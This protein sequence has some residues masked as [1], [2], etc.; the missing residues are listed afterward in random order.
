MN[1]QPYQIKIIDNISPLGL[2][3]FPEH[4]YQV[5]SDMK[6]PLAILVRSSSLHD[7]ALASK[8]IVVGRAGAGVNNIPVN[9]YTQLGIPVLNAPGANANAVKELVIAGLLLSS[10]H[11]CQSWQ[12]A[13]QLV[14]N[15]QEI[16]H[17]LEKAKKQ[18]VGNE[19]QGQT[20]GIIGLGSIGVRVANAAIALGMKVIGFDPHITSTNAWQIAS[21]VINATKI[22]QLLKQA[23]YVSLHIP[24]NAQTKH[25]LDEYKLSLLKPNAVLMNFA[26]A[27][28]IDHQALFHALQQQQ[29]ACY[30]SD[31]PC[32]ILQNLPNVINL[33]HL[34][35]STREAQE[36]CAVM[37]ADQVRDY[38]EFGH[39]RHSV[40]FP[41][42]DMPLL[43]GYRIA[44][45]NENIPNMVA[46]ISTCLSDAGL[47]IIDL[48]NKSQDDIAYTLIDVDKPVTSALLA[49]LGEIVGVVRVR[50]IA[51]EAR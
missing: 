45:V 44:I 18:F 43:D 12:F 33:P 48:L 30:V 37:V 26:R 8:T 22:E 15:D 32:Q 21:Q 34:G 25:L 31:F 28:I 9:R 42:I 39:I 1:T 38:L 10:R 17:T 29:L 27:G 47:N 36:N 3:R 51:G 20:L 49:A 19:I 46:Q 40:N 7:Y 5:G 41:D 6:N 14:G 23:D 16:N 50:V 11:I 4:R 24:L 13:Q 35:A 2:A